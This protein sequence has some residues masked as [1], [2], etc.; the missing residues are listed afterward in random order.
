MPPTSAV[1]VVEGSLGSRTKNF[2]MPARPIATKES[3]MNML[4]P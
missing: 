3:P 2:S 4:Y 1:T